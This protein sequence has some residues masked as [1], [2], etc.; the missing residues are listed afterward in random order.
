LSKFAGG[1]FRQMLRGAS[2]AF[3]PLSRFRA[4]QTHP[5]TGAVSVAPENFAVAL[6]SN[7]TVFS[8][9]SASFTSAAAANDYLARAVNKDPTLAGTI[10]V[11]PN[12]ELAA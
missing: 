11:L 8:A 7:N 5:F 3:N 6:T 4:T 10:H 2:V 12:F 9:D 1:F